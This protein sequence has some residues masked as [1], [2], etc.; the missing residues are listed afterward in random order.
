MLLIRT[1]Y[2]AAR[3]IPIGLQNSCYGLSFHTTISGNNVNHVYA[4]VVCVSWLLAAAQ[5]YVFRGDGPKCSVRIPFRS[6]PCT[7]ENQHALV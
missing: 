4:G 2:S 3:K 1:K 5:F 7:V 6:V